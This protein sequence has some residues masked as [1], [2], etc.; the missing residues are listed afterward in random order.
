MVAYSICTQ[1]EQVAPRR[2]VARAFAI[3]V[4]V[5][6]RCAPDERRAHC[7]SREAARAAAARLARSLVEDV[8]ARGNSVVPARD[9]VIRLPT[10]DREAIPSTA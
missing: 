4:D 2:F 10:I 9:P 7:L 3:P 6:E 8:L 5:G 1:I